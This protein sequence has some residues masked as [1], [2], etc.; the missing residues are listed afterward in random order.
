MSNASELADRIGNL[1]CDAVP[2]PPRLSKTDKL[3]NHQYES[4]GK[5]TNTPNLIG[6]NSS[7]NN[8][9]SS[10]A[11][12]DS[13][14]SKPKKRSKSKTS[15]ETTFNYNI[16][17]STNVKIAPTTKHVYNLNNIQH[18]DCASANRCKEEVKTMLPHIKTLSY[19][20][21]EITKDDILLIKDHLGKGWKELAEKIGYSKGQ[22]EQFVEN[23]MTKG[24]DEVIY[25]ILID[26]K[27]SY[28]KDATIGRLVC[29]M[30]SSRE[31][32]CVHQLAAAHTSI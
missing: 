13:R 5:K 23:H 27:Q 16:I 12:T 32:D 18:R 28:T 31:Y 21:S 29:D 20:N 17:N 4:N 30:W 15:T 19:N 7:S 3:N 25:R 10:K 14:D 8:T 2:D 24:V 1:V 22:I 6:I 9:D 26:W 11:T